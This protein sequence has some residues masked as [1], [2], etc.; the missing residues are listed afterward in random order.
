MQK[1]R[2]F[3]LIEPRKPSQI[4]RRLLI[5]PFRKSGRARGSHGFTLIELLVAMALISL[6]ATIGMAGF[7]ASRRNARNAK[8]RGD[9]TALQTA[10]EQR[11]TASDGVY[12]ATCNAIVTEGYIQGSFPGDPLKGWN[13]YSGTTTCT[14]A[15]YCFCARLE[16]ADGN[17]SN[18]S[19]TFSGSPL[20]WFCVQNQQ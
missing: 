16:N 14:A 15:S 1:R 12:P 9:M 5:Q 2:G 19:C 7:T 17:A 6:L 20:E 13:P 10:F 8:R 4:F 11:Y 3:T 18:G